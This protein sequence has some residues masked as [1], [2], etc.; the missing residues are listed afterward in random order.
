MNIKC[1]WMAY[2][3]KNKSYIFNALEYITTVS[4]FI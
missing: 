4:M 2:E 3:N 1:N